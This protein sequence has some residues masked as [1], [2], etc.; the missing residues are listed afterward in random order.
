MDDRE[1]EQ[2]RLMVHR[3]I[4]RRELLRRAAALG[5]GVPALAALLVACGG[6]GEAPPTSAPSGGSGGTG[7]TGSSGEAEG[8]PGTGGGAASDKGGELHVVF[9][10]DEPKVLDAQ[11]DPF[12]PAAMVCAW[13]ADTLVAIDRDG[14][15]IP[16]LAT[17]WTTSEDGTTWTFTLRED[18]TFHDGTPFNAEAA[19]FNFDRILDP[20]TQSAQAAAMLGP[21][22]STEVVDEFTF[23]V[24]HE[25][26]YVP[27]LDS[28]S[29]GFI[30]MW[31]PT[32]VQQYGD[33]FGLHC[34]G[35]GP[36][37]LE[38]A[39]PAEHYVLVKNPDY[40][41]A[42]AYAG[43]S[44]PAYLDRV[45]VRWIKE[46][47]TAIAALN[48]G[49]A[50]VVIGFPPES[51]ADFSGDDYQVVKAE[52]TGSPT[53]YVMNTEKAP[54]DDINV[55]KALQHAINQEEIV[56]VLFKGEAIPTK[57]VMYPA[58]R[59]YWEGG[60]SVYP[61]D[62]EKAGEMLDQ[63]GWT[64]GS[65]GIREKDG[66]KLQVT[67]VNA[68][69]EDLGTIVQAQLLQAGVDAKIELVPG[70]VQLERATSGDFHLIFQHFAY[71]DPGVLDML[72][73]S[74]NAKPGGWSWTRFKNE[75]LDEV[76]DQSSLTV[77]D[78]K[79]GELLTEAQQIIV[80]NAI[81]LPLYGRYYHF[82]MAA[83]V[84]DFVV[85]PRARVDVWLN[86]TY[87]AE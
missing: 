20:A 39:K 62:I 19:K 68:F 76:L 40:N 21:V 26:P 56:Q 32:A 49:E 71:T 7:G 51:V 31:S 5:L 47:T 45:V 77:D 69:I 72:Y 23:R 60:E 58:S 6:G 24:T 38:E 42:P 65:D 44:G 12:D 28:I 75:R 73:N 36:F 67:I 63:A 53:L 46:N 87:V 1:L 81:V 15:F 50:D 16:A 33:S 52:L 78:E 9:V 17:E 30:P 57:S 74:K 10:G 70:P 2:R 29:K 4:D 48:A 25:E 64:L 13:L 43:H 83:K 66:Q 79:R 54:L 11:V 37:I 85:G 84:K 80:E 18:V 35:S 82:V 22:Q 86:D 41:W 3:Q 61:F 55:R 14:K 59:Y 27:F 8:T 34:V